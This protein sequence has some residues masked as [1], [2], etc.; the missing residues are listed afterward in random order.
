MGYPLLL[1]FS[2]Q[3]ADLIKVYYIDEGILYF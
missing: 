1:P 3:I 2:E